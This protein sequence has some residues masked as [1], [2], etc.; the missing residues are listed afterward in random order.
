VPTRL[1]ADSP[2][3]GIFR[4]EKPDCERVDGR[5]RG[6]DVELWFVPESVSVG[7]ATARSWRGVTGA[8]SPQSRCYNRS[9]EKRKTLE[10]N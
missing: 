8:T 4:V 2:H 10:L 7:V 9:V 5:L 1:P 3:E 6:K